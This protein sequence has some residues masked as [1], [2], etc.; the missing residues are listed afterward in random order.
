ML[1]RRTSQMSFADADEWWKAIPTTAVWALIR[2]WTGQHFRDEDFAGWYSPIGRPSVPPSYL[3]TLNLLQFREGWSD[4]QAVEEARF[5]DRVKYALGVSRTPE[6]TCDHSTLCKYR[7][8]FLDADLGRTLLRQ[9]LLDAQAAGLLGDAEDLIDSFM[10]AGA[11]ARQGTL[12]L[13]RQGIRRVLAEIEDAGLTV[14]A[15][16]RADYA[17]RKKPAID[18]NDATA[19]QA[20]LQGLVADAR[21]LYDHFHPQAE[22]LSQSLQQALELLHVVTEQDITTDD[23]GRTTIAQQVA[24]DRVI[25]TVDPD[26]RHGRK[27]SSKKF[28]GYKGHVSIQ[29]Q[30]V[31]KGAFVTAAEVTGGNVADGDAAPAVL[32][33]REANTGAMPQA[34]MGDTSYGGTSVRAAVAEV[35]PQTQVIAPVPPAS[36][37]GGHFAKTDFAID[38]QARTI[39]CPAGQAAAIPNRRPST[40]QDRPQSVTFPVAMCA[41]CALR[42]QCVGESRGPR[43][44]TLPRMRR[45]CKKNADTN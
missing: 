13:I 43:H 3:L 5:D 36:N 34:L 31:G 26:M 24:P 2:T 35:A 32:T 18:W 29:N 7:A 45:R 30:P 11:A 6:I 12:T 39:T 16:Q 1:G 10:V 22:G 28:D 33:E 20:L 8:R 9:T 41:G 21:T 25:S 40:S 38:L 42:S 19:R 44:I 23:Q 27:S 14:P 17:A 15:L 4:R 37:R